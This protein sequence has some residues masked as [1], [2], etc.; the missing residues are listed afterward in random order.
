MGR[1]AAHVRQNVVGYLALFVALGG[2]SYAAVE[3]QKNSVDSKAIK[4]NAVKAP[5]IAK[6]AVRTAEVK[7]GSLLDDDF[8]P[9]QL[10]AGTEGPEG[11]QGQ[12]GQPGAAGATNL[13]VRSKTETLPQTCTDNGVQ[14]NCRSAP[15]LVTASCNPGERATGGG[16]E[17]ISEGSSGS[18]GSR[19]SFVRRVDRFEPATGTPTGWTVEAGGSAVGETGSPDP[20]PPTVTVYVGCA[21][22]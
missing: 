7:D 14:N 8:A 4:K 10:P 16:F 22:P 12:P 5:E 17:T 6:N 21:A 1:I 19:R 20:P 18:V 9:G 2:V 13:T 15:I 11:P 3:L